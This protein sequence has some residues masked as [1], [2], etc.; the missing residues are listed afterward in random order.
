[1]LYLNDSIGN[2]GNRE[3]Y[4]FRGKVFNLKKEEKY[5]DINLSTSEKTADGEYRN[6]SWPTRF[7]GGALAKAKELNEGDNIAIIKAK[8][9]N[10]YIKDKGRSYLN[11]I[12]YDFASSSEV[13]AFDEAKRAVSNTDPNA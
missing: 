3:R 6:S 8:L 12:V 2:G 9:E 4:A 5:V 13:Q 7:V 1:M 11:L 10:V